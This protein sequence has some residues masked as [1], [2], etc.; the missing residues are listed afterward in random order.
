MD[1]PECTRKQPIQEKEKG[2]K[3]PQHSH[4]QPILSL[5]C[6]VAGKAKNAGNA[7]RLT[8]FLLDVGTV[9]KIKRTVIDRPTTSKKES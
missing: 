2:K 6:C 3:N 4:S 1:R 9:T 5:Y 7:T 8:L